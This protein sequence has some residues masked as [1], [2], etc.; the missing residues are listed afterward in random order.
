MHNHPVT[1]DP[2][3][4]VG[5]DIADDAGVYRMADGT[6]LLQTVDYFTPVVDDPYDWGRI[7]ASNALSDIYAMGGTPMTAMQ[8]IGWPRDGLSFDVLDRVIAGGIDILQAAGCVL[9]G[10]HTVDDPEPKYGFSIAG[11]VEESNLITIRDARPGDILVLTKPLG[12]GA[13]G[14]ALKAGAAPDGVVSAA[15]ATMTALNDGAA[16]AM[17]EVGA[18]AGTDVTGFGLL[19]HLSEMLHASQAGARIYAAQVPLI[20]GLRPLVDAG[21]FPAGSGRNLDAVRPTLVVEGVDDSTIR[22]LAD[23]QTSGGILMA[24]APDR[25]DAMLAALGREQ[26]PAM[27]VIGEVIEDDCASIL[28]V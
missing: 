9:I 13:I 15:V 26:T 27:A 12:T 6:L 25:V 8:L 20:E 28:L 23:A 19:G 16:R 1:A 5:L 10:G 7:A 17:N 22:I 21:Y 2:N 3:L 24:V 4:V 14:A 11:I 18:R